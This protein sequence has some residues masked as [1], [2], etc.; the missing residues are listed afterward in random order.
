M[1]GQFGNPQPSYKQTVSLPQQYLAMAAPCGLPRTWLAVSHVIADG[2]VS[3][4]RRSEATPG[5]SNGERM[6]ERRHTHDYDTPMAHQ[7]PGFHAAAQRM[8]KCTA[9]E[10]SPGFVVMPERTQSSV[11]R[12]YHPCG[13]RMRI[14]STRF[15]TSSLKACTEEGQCTMGAREPAGERQ[16]WRRG[17]PCAPLHTQPLGAGDGLLWPNTHK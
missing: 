6:R 10:E 9:R 15:G 8:G 12:R 17:F 13:R 16:D 4:I 3:N 11:S 5:C 1:E 7:D 2:A 14:P